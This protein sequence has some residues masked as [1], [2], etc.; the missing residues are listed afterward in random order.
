M[1]YVFKTPYEFDGKSYE[2]LEFDLEG[3]KGSDVAAVKK[4]FTNEGN[5]VPIPAVDNDFCARIVARAAKL[6]I[7]F[8]TD[9]PVR[10]YLGITQQVSNFLLG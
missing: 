3:L 1:E 5:F 4:Q 2:K 9:M 6:P 8:F 7:E 10:D